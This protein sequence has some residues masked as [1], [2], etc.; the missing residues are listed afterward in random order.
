MLPI[1]F[2]VTSNGNYLLYCCLKCYLF[3]LL[4]PQMLPIYLIV[5]SNGTYLL[6]IVAS[7]GTYNGTLLFAAKR[8]AKI[9][10][11]L[12][13]GGYYYYLTAGTWGRWC[14]TIKGL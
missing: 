12:R 5:T 8:C 14:L 10:E 2:I 6:Y 13:R 4:L 7:N 11:K 9:S 3:T 1:Y